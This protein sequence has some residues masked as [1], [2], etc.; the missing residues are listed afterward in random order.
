MGVSETLIVYFRI[1]LAD[2]IAAVVEAHAIW[3]ISD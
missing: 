3:E 2:S 1:S